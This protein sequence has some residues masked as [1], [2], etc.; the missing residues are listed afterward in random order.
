[1]GPAGTWRAGVGDR[2]IRSR[3]SGTKWRPPTANPR[4]A[5]VGNVLAHPL[6]PVEQIPYLVSL[7]VPTDYCPVC[8]GRGT[9]R[10]AECN[11]SESGY[12]EPETHLKRTWTII[13]VK[14]VKFSF[15][16]YQPLFGQPK[17]APGHD[18]W[19]QIRDSDGTV[20]LCFH[21]WGAHEHPSLTSPDKALP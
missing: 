16:W 21:E 15:Q 11:T 13:G 20:L 12:L 7:A 3:T 10:R 5:G 9:D 17:T 2:R 4:C 8:D 1:M 14:E 6:Q 19:S 18:Y